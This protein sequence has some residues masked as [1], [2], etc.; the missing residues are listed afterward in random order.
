MDE[1]E[2]NGNLATPWCEVVFLY[3]HSNIEKGTENK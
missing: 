2:L 1:E 3:E